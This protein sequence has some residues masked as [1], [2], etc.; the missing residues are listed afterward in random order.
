MASPVSTS[1]RVNWKSLPR[2]RSQASIRSIV[3]D[4]RGIVRL[5]R[6]NFN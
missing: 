6:D 1:T 3:P 5:S 2:V 4:T